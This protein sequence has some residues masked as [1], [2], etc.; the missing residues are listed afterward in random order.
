[1]IV[2]REDLKKT[3]YKILRAHR[4]TTGYANFD[5]LHSDDNYEPTELMKER[6]AK[7]KPFKVWDKVS[8]ARQIKRLASVD[9]MDYIFD[10]FMELHGD[11]YFRD[12]PAIVGGIAY[13]D[14]QPG[15]QLSVS[16]REKTLRTAQRE[17]MV[18][19]HR[20][21]TARHCAS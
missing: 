11:R 18:C 5:P 14:G 21:A 6:E 17:T 4:P 9:Y 1:M 13:L 3:L 15:L 7:A 12:D 20:R 10:E 8:A 16:T 19:H 2:E